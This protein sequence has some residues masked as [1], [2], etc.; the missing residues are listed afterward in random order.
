MIADSF[1]VVRNHATTP[2]DA[3][4]Q[5]PLLSLNDIARCRFDAHLCSGPRSR[6]RRPRRGGDGFDTGD[7]TDALENKGLDVSAWSFDARIE[8]A[9]HKGLIGS[10]C[11]RLPA[12]ARRYRDLS[13]AE[14]RLRD[15]TISERD[16]R[17]ARQVLLVVMR[18]L[19]PRR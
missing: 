15:A 6:E 17:V 13:D 8:A 11:V 14:G 4:N 2:R 19:D 3:E 1:R 16:T 9:Q 12:V 18:D 7:R 10:G 5:G